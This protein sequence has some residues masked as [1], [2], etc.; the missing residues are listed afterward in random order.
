MFIAMKSTGSREEVE[1]AQSAISAM[2]AQMHE[3]FDY[4]IPKTEISR[5]AVIIQKI[6][7]TPGKYPRRFAKIQR[8]PL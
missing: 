7:R 8:A 6:K 4:K 5:R 1:E 3:S 2:G